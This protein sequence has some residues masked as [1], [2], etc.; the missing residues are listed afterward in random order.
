MGMSLAATYRDVSQEFRFEAMSGSS[1]WRP[2]Q[3]FNALPLLPPAA[4][5]DSKA[6]LKRRIAARAALAE[7]KQVAE[8]L[9]NQAVLINTFPLLEAKDSS[10]TCSWSST[11]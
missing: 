10:E 3:P 9:P 5:L 1:S 11:T 8:L 6:V 4:V 2:E 7:L